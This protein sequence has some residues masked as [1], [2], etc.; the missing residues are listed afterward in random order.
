[1]INAATVHFRLDFLRRRV[2]ENFRKQDDEYRTQTLH[3]IDYW[4]RGWERFNKTQRRFVMNNANSR[5]Q[6][7]K[8]L[9]K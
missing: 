8:K 2:V 9:R 4:E 5:Y 7:F 1:M 3:D 6:D